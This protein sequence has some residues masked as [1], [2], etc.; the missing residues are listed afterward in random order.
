MEVC[1]GHR[2]HAA[3][4]AR[5]LF[6]ARQNIAVKFGDAEL[7]RFYRQM[8]ALEPETVALPPQGRI[9]ECVPLTTETT[10]MSWRLRWSAVPIIC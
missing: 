2:F 6:E 3:L 10:P 9:D 7:V 8:A 5:V 1:R 4:S